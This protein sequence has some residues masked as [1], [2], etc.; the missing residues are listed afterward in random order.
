MLAMGTAHGRIH[1]VHV[2]APHRAVRRLDGHLSNVVQLTFNH[3]GDLLLS[4]S[5]DST[6]R[7]WRVS[8]GQQVLQFDAM[9]ETTPLLGTG[10]RQD[11]RQLAL[12]SGKAAF[13]LWDVAGGGP[14]RI[15]SVAGETPARSSVQFHPA[16]P[17]L[18]ASSTADGVELWDAGVGRR[19]TVLAAPRAWSA[20]FSPD[21]SGLYSSS[22]SGLQF[23]PLADTSVPLDELQVGEPETIV[24]SNTERIDLAVH[25]RL[26]AVDCGFLDAKLYDLDDGNKVRGTFQHRHL[27]HVAISPDARWMVTTT[28]KGR[29]VV[30]W[31]LEDGKL[32]CNLAPEV[33]SATPAFSPDGRW[34]AV[35]DGYAYHLWEVGTWRRVH[36]IERDHQD[37]WPGPVA[38]SPDGCLLA[39]PHTRYVAQLIDPQ[40]G[41][42]LGILEA[43]GSTSLSGYAFSADSRYLAIADAENI[44]L[45]DLSA[46]HQELE[47]LQIPWPAR[48]GHSKPDGVAGIASDDSRSNAVH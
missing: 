46:V 17:E 5:W 32:G 18:L 31:D 43:P 15:L 8:T 7:L 1:L 20:V 6:S 35:S 12:A 44:Q 2:Q 36:R 10:F 19:V 13:G 26:L 39:V 21:G 25:R 45:W 3:G 38:F 23:W 22:A 27:D 48:R 28:W 30:V 4:R 24:P 29:G 42:T 14:L 37:G 33:G 40:T 11:D 9:L 41:K 16:R 34:L 47:R